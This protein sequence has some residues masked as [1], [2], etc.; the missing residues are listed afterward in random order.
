MDSS[1]TIA[2][3][4]SHINI[5]RRWLALPCAI[6]HITPWPTTTHPREAPSTFSW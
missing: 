6:V 4:R 1:I 2:Q 5:P 3:L